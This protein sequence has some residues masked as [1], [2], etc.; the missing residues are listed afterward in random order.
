[1]TKTIT[2]LP[3]VVITPQDQ[4]RGRLPIVLAEAALKYGPIFRY[5]PLHYNYKGDGYVY[6]VGPE[7]NRFVLHSHRHHFSNDEGWTPIIGKSLGQG[8]L[9]MDDPEHAVHRKMCNPAFSRAYMERYIPLMQRVIAQRTANWHEGAIVDVH[10]EARQITFD[11]VGVALAGLDSS[12]E[13]EQLQSLFYRILH[14]YQRGRE[15]WAK[16]TARREQ[17]RH[18]LSA[19]LLRMIEERRREGKADDVLGMMV[20]A[21][22]D[23]G[24][25]LSD[26]QILAHINILL[27]AGHETTTTLSAWALYKLATLPKEHAKILTEL[28]TVLAHH[29]TIS[30]GVLQEMSHLDRFVREVGR[31]HPPIINLPR[32]VLKPFTFEGYHIIPKRRIRLS[33]AACHR[34]PHIFS[35][36]KEF[37]PTRFAPPREEDRQTPYSLVTFGAGARICI[38]INF[39]QIEI[40]LLIAHLLRTFTFH[41]IKGKQPIGQG[42]WVARL[43]KGIHLRVRKRKN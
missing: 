42:H 19:L 15:S 21:S 22:D 41:P 17:T 23:H 13:L 27:V 20:H 12:I 10:E 43:P 35:N 30:F 1:M 8:L 2:N 26:E 29:D 38:G 11:V 32:G 34:L 16:F 25:S 4:K 6:M 40:K 18:Q 3:K 14:G 31:L 36:P 33:L 9:N 5:V 37:D 28:D 7:A 39:A 24:E